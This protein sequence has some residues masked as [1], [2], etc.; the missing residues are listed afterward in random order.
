LLFHLP[1]KL[2]ERAS[3]IITPNLSFSE[4]AAAFGGAK[5]T[6]TTLLDRLTYRC[7]IL[8]IRND[9]FRFKNSSTEAAN[10]AKENLRT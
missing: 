7:H 4:R 8:E 1:S 6:T 3:V 10:P 2:Y 9:S 5:T